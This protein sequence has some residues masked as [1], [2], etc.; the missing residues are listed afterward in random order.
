[1]RKVLTRTGTKSIHHRDVINWVKRGKCLDLPDGVRQEYEYAVNLLDGDEVE[2]LAKTGAVLLH[3]LTH[4]ERMNYVYKTML[5]EVPS[6]NI[7]I[8]RSIFNGWMKAGLVD[9]NDMKKAKDEAKMLKEALVPSL[10]QVFIALEKLPNLGKRG[11]QLP[12]LPDSENLIAELKEMHKKAKEWDCQH[13]FNF[14]PALNA[15]GD[16]DKTP[17]MSKDRI[18]QCVSTLHAMKVD[19]QS[20]AMRKAISAVV[21]VIDDVVVPDGVERINIG[22]NTVKKVTERMISHGYVGLML[23]VKNHVVIKDSHVFPI[24]KK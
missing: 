20:L 24:K 12:W 23:T 1:M 6:Q 7:Q 15:G 19:Y 13:G 8:W 17:S 18:R 14:L 4:D 10:K 11:M 3:A 22:S 5:K 21:S 9:W 16:I 2:G